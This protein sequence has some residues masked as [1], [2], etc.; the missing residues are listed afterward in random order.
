MD[1]QVQPP[2]RP[3]T[4]NKSNYGQSHSLFSYY[5][6]K[7][8]VNIFKRSRFIVNIINDVNVSS[9]EE[10]CILEKCRVPNDSNY[11]ANGGPAFYAVEPN[12]LR[13][14]FFS[15][16]SGILLHEYSQKSP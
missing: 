9:T 12:S 15:I 14:S 3:A 5:Q 2:N 1:F 7:V 13:F 8:L 4:S 16:L 11:R 6:R 10:Q